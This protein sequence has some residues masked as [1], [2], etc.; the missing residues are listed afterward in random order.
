MRHA[1]SSSE[2]SECTCRWTNEFN[3]KSTYDG[4]TGADTLSYLR[5]VRAPC[6]RDQP[7]P[8]PAGGRERLAR[9]EPAARLRLIP[10]RR[11]RQ[12]RRH[13]ATKVV[14]RGWIFRLHFF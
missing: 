14:R 13:R 10:A 12:R 9:K 5:P 6:E 1:P 2:Y 7:S 8:E 4:R 11:A 3:G